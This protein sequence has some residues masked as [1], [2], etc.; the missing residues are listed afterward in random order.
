MTHNPAD[1][2]ETA[3]LT[4][5]ALTHRTPRGSLFDE[6]PPTRGEFPD[7]GLNSWATRIQMWFG[8]VNISWHVVCDEQGVMDISKSV[9]FLTPNGE[10]VNDTRLRRQLDL[11]EMTR[12]QMAEIICEE[13]IG[14]P[15][16]PLQSRKEVRDLIAVAELDARYTFRLGMQHILSKGLGGNGWAEADDAERWEE[17]MRAA[18]ESAGFTH[19]HLVTW[20][21]ACVPF[22]S[23]NVYDDAFT[24]VAFGLMETLYPH[25]RAVTTTR[26]GS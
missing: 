8:D 18:D 24:E 9:S 14:T 21:K 22:F 6:E 20:R 11:N 7:T 25:K 13:I 1:Y 15:Y 23:V 2:Y 4:L 3:S 26:K 5:T 17:V 19:G 16:I 10:P 12:G